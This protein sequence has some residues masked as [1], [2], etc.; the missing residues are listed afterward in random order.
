MNAKTGGRAGKN[1]PGA[2]GQN[3]RDAKPAS[4]AVLLE[5]VARIRAEAVLLA[6]RAYEAI[7]RH[8]FDPYRQFCDKRAEH[9]A[10]VS[11]L[12]SRIGPKPKDPNWLPAVN[13]LRVLTAAS[14]GIPAPPMTT[15]KW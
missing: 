7:Q 11:V 15:R 12:R 2:H 8:A 9:A 14:P 10:L 1:W 3:L 5:A 4:I 13:S 6:D